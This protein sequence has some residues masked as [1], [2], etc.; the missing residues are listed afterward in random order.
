MKEIIGTNAGIVWD[1]LNS[2]KGKSTSIS[3]L[4]K[5]CKLTVKDTYAALGWLAREG[6]VAFNEVK[7]DYEVVL[8]E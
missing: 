3:D 2:Q 8:I 7:D 6:K 4:R 1:Y 5:G